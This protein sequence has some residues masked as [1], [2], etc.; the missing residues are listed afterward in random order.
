MPEVGVIGIE[1]R[2]PHTHT[3]W[4]PSRAVLVVRSRQH[5]EEKTGGVERVLPF[6]R[7]AQRWECVG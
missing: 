6:E 7:K 1:A 2:K 3:S 5:R 4:K